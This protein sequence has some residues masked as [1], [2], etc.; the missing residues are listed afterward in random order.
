MRL[1]C[2]PPEFFCWEEIIRSNFGAMRAALPGQP[3]VEGMA[4]MQIGIATPVENRE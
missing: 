2:F 3:Q 1:S 4:A